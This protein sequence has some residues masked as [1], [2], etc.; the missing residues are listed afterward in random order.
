MKLDTRTLWGARAG[1]G[2]VLMLGC[3]GGDGMSPTLGDTGSDSM[4]EALRSPRRGPRSPGRGPGHGNGHGH[5]KGGHHHHGPGCGHPPNG[6]GKG[7][8]GGTG[9]GSAGSGTGTGAANGSGGTFGSAGGAG[10]SSGGSGGTFSGGGSSGSAGGGF[11]V[12][13]DLM[14]DWDEQCD[15]GN[16]VSGD[17]CDACVLEPGYTCEWGGGCHLVVCGDGL[18]ENY[19][20]TGGNWVTEQCDDG[21]AASG[22]G[23]SG[24]CVIEAGHMCEWNGPCHEV[25]CGDSLQ[26]S[27]ALGDGNFAYEGCDDGN[28]ASGDGCSDE[29]AMEP[30]FFCPTQGVS[31]REIEC[32]DGFQDYWWE[33]VDGGTG[34]TGGSGAGSGG[35]GG[36]SAGAGGGTYTIFHSEQCDDGNT[37]SAD[38]C[39]SACEVEAGWICEVPAAPCRQ[40]TCGDGY[41]DF[42]GGGGTSGSGGT[43]MG[44]FASGTSGSYE[45]CDDGNE[46]SGDGCDSACTYEPGYYCPGPGNP[47]ELA[48]CGNGYAEWPAE[49][50]DDGN[51]IPNDGC[52]D[53]QYDG[54]WAGAG[55][56]TGGTGMSGAGG[57]TG[58]TGMG[59]M[60]P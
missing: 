25:I 58:G 18:Q 42:I 34:G 44:G 14:P 35:T 45:E 17:G 32:G 10:M 37:T 26:E 28:A 9:S 40:P 15:D 23:C 21:N 36:G 33:E 30:G 2:F 49:V 38:G 43:G 52:A 27:Y 56:S 41:I 22:D 59:G 51:D 8:S 7:G 16:A 55:G 60:R 24:S 13:G 31:C 57:S 53:C 11:G 54:G 29:C 48:V 39:S 12:C 47:C 3:S 1:L 46:A 5:G 6:G 50:C 4:E 20:D 19:V